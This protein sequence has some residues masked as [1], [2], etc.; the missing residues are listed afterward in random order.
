MNPLN[1][2]SNLPTH[3]VLNMP[4]HL[5]DQ[6]LW[7]DDVA[8]RETV[9]RE[10]AGWAAEKLAG[11]GQNTGT[12]EMFHKADMANRNH[13]E[14]KAYDRYGN[15]LNSV[16]Y[17]PTY[18]DLMAHAIEN[19]VHSFPWNHPQAGAQV[20]YAALVYMF[21]QVEGGVMC[22]MAMAYSVIPSLR[23]SPA[24][25][26]EWIP[27]VLSTRYD[28]RD[29]PV[30]EKAG[31][32]LGMFMTE[33]QGGSDVRANSTQAVPLNGKTGDGAEYLLTGHKFFCSAPMCD[34]FL[35]LAYTETGLSCFLVPRWRPDNV[36]NTLYIQRLK[37]K[38]GNRSNAS[39]EIEL[40]DTYGV[41]LGPDGRGLQTI[42]QMVTGNRYY[43]AAS[44]AG[45]MRQ[46]LV[47]AHHHVAHRSAFGKKL[48]DQPLMRN[49]LA[50]LAIESEAA[51]VL[52]MRLGRAM[53]ESENDPT[54]KA[55]ARIGTAIAK[56]WVC[57]RAPMQIGE[58]LECLGGSGYIEESIIPRLYREA[59]LNSIWEG[60]GN[61]MCLDVL[62]AMGREPEA[63][64][65]VLQEL[66][67]AK[68][69]NGLL[70]GAIESLKN[71]LAD[72]DH[73]QLR[74]RAITEK[75]AL[76]LQGSL[77][78]RHGNQ[79]VADAFCESRLGPNRSGAFGALSPHTDFETIIGR[80]KQ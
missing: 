10:G 26:E 75:L 20:G 68:G 58:A 49:V 54:A 69:A 36:R 50:D 28:K 4:P 13:P 41:M 14:L 16:E 7:Q 59:P 15:R 42:M 64:P 3:E 38:L 52:T 47:R 46:A 56:Y 73:I 61:V 45:L 11:F 70:D 23:V 21:N 57:K 12:A 9:E 74:A 60:S 63:V 17:H 39:S 67:Q 66:E 6:N 8:L 37:D 5:G 44:S 43:C 29:I 35:T 48:I 24:L 18:H 22:P 40:Q 33:K 62:R 72:E 1:P 19:E 55:F 77:L 51:L 25:A 30:C 80:I 79:A 53:D 2:I 34:A 31:A 27:R 32:V 65:A 76:T 78:V 71:D